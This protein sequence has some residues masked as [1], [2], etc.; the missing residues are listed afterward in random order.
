MNSPRTVP[1]ASTPGLVS[2]EVASVGSGSS[3]A[4]YTVFVLTLCAGENRW[5]LE[6]TKAVRKALKY[7][8]D[9]EE[10]SVLITKS[11]SP[12]FFSNGLDLASLQA[13]PSIVTI[14][15]AEVMG[16]FADVLELP[17]PTICLIEGH[18]FGAVRCVIA[19]VHITD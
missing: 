17:I 8:S 10:A 4:E 9:V 12:K 11:A 1:T 14:L 2:L 16:A 18:A 7:V 5:N 15:G 13:N 6:F 3:K 19:R